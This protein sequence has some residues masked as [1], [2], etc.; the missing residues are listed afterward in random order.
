VEQSKAMAWLL[1]IRNENGQVADV[2]VQD[3]ASALSAV[4]AYRSSGR[5]AWIVDGTGRIIDERTGQPS[6]NLS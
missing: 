2:I 6:Q 4:T 3:W 5:E 1:K